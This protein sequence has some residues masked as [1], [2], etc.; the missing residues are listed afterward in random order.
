[1]TTR[2]FPFDTRVSSNLYKYCSPR[3]PWYK[4]TNKRAATRLTGKTYL[5][6]FSLQTNAMHNGERDKALLLAKGPRAKSRVAAET[7]R[8]GAGVPASGMCEQGHCALRGHAHAPSPP[9]PASA[10]PRAIVYPRSDR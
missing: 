5:A 2:T 7:S 6:L 8:P 1:M 9:T 3:K 10:R 4:L